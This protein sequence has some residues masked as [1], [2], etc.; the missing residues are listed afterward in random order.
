MLHAAAQLK[1]G[2]IPAGRVHVSFE[3]NKFPEHFSH[4]F[5]VNVSPPEQHELL[6]KQLPGRS[7]R[8]PQ[9]SK[10][11]LQPE[12][13]AARLL[14]RMYASAP[15]TANARQRKTSQNAPQQQPLQ[16]FVGTSHEC[17]VSAPAVLL[18][19][20]PKIAFMKWD[21]NSL[22]KLNVV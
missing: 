6:R 16:Y 20:P 21:H 7:L 9:Q 15:P 18:L 14:P 13:P 1:V 2:R 4:K 12:P 10:P 22:L 17:Q 8:S 3:G 11:S 5:A 19:K